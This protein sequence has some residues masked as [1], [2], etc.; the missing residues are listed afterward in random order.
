VPVT[1]PNRGRA[2]LLEREPI[3]LMD[4]DPDLGAALAPERRAP[5]ERA[6]ADATLLPFAEQPGC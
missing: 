4:V 3:R 5:A 6:P 2:M 1:V